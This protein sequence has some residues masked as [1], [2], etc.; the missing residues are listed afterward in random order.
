MSTNAA[1]TQLTLGLKIIPTATINSSQ[2]PRVKFILENYGLVCTGVN[3][4][5][6][7]YQTGG[8]NYTYTFTAT[9]AVS[10]TGNVI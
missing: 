9:P 10:C 5:V 4:F 7:I 2:Y 1:V 6:V 8:T 3:R